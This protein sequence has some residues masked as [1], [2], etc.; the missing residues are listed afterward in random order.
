VR[1]AYS[2]LV[3]VVITS[4]IAT[5][6][7]AEPVR[8]SNGAFSIDIDTDGLCVG[9]PVPLHPCM[10]GD[11]RAVANGALGAT[12]NSVAVFVARKDDALEVIT[13]VRSDRADE[14]E[15]D[16]DEIVQF[17]RDAEKNTRRNPAVRSATEM[18]YREQ[19]VNGVQV[20]T[21]STELQIDAQS[22]LSTMQLE[23]RVLYGRKFAY[24]I[25]VFG[26]A[27]TIEDARR[28]V[29]AAL[30]TVQLEPALREKPARTGRSWWWLLV[31]GLIGAEIGRRYRSWKQRSRETTKRG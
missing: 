29:T 21:Y 20:V 19:R 16:G 2:K 27:T 18:K 24:W 17:A 10:S 26:D 1:S 28:R 11:V 5:P 3:A 7:L 31:G 12:A 6:A 23:S 4:V 14:A 13:I 9:L 8:D 22:G 15:L 25:T 30:A